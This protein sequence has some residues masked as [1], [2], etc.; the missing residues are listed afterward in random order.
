MSDPRWPRALLSA[1]LLA[2]ALAA[3][4]PAAAQTGRCETLAE[5]ADIVE[6]EPT[7][8]G[9]V[10]VPVAIH[11]MERTGTPCRVRRAWTSAVVRRLFEDSASDRAI[12]SIWD[13]TRVRF[14]V[15]E[16]AIHHFDPPA[17]LTNGSGTVLVPT[18]GP[19]G[20][21]RWERA[22]TRLVTRFHRPG[23]VNVYLWSAIAPDQAGFGRSTRSGR[24]KATV[25]LAGK[26]ADGRMTPERCA[27]IVAHELGHAL[28]LYHSGPNRC[29]TV[30][31]A[32]RAVCQRTSAP[33]AEA[34]AAQRL[35]AS[36]MTGRRLCPLEAEAAEEMAASIE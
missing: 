16:I 36:G 27:R 34:T 8:A 15:R 3:A 9:I 20:P 33:C 5:Y 24:G 26:C 21:A 1:L 35:M 14:V 18:T 31:P 2:V 23:H 4:A 28:G 30:Q 10:T 25:W 6:P 32:F 29:A 7:T 17:A 13:G 22:F 11:L 19:L 12:A